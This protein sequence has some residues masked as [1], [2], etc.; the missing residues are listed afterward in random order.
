MAKEY[1]YESEGRDYGF[2]IQNSRPDYTYSTDADWL[3]FNKVGNRLNVQALENT[4]GANR[5]ATITVTNGE[6]T[7]EIEI[8]QLDVS[9]V[10]VHGV[11]QG[12]R[13]F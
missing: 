2:R 8:Y 6:Y 13:C 10:W 12:H 5:A 4:T 1:V 9:P 7:E 3:T 11:L